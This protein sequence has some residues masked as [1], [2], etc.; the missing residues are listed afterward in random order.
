M[1]L[2]N[3]YFISTIYF[4]TFLYFLYI[5]EELRFLYVKYSQTS[6]FLLILLF[7]ARFTGS[8]ISTTLK[9]FSPT[10]FNDTTSL[11]P[12]MRKSFNLYM[13][14]MLSFYLCSLT[15]FPLCS[16]LL[17]LTFLFCFRSLKGTVA[18]LYVSTY[19]SIPLQNLIISSRDFLIFDYLILVSFS[20]SCDLQ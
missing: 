11:R 5:C 1:S 20:G 6:S 13:K 19:F 4:I 15:Y 9:A 17:V 3:F 10:F 7:R 14:S 18:I 2:Q 8:S 12:L 16:F